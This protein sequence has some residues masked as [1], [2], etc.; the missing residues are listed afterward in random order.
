MPAAVSSFLAYDQT[1]A[2]EASGDVCIAKEGSQAAV[3]TPVCDLAFVS[4]R[5]GFDAL[6]A[7]WNAL[8]ERA[9]RSTQLFQR[10]NWLWHWC[11]HYLADPQAPGRGSRLAIVTARREGRL[12]MVW[13]LVSER[14]GGYQ[15]A[16]VDGRPRRPVRRC[17]RR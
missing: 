1:S 8:F 13:P 3:Q 17:P 10:F 9:G 11:N 15:D 14:A 7:E 5:A 6:E 16:L 2:R 12:V 4:D